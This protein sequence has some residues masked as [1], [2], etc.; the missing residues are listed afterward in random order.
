MKTWKTRR[1]VIL[2]QLD[3]GRSG[4]FLIKQDEMTLLVDTSIPQDGL[5]LASGLMEMGY[6]PARPVDYLVLTHSHFDHAGNA[7]MIQGEFL[8]TVVVH[9]LENE[10]L[11]KGSSPVPHG[12]SW[13]VDQL[14]TTF[15]RLA[16]GMTEFPA[17]AGDILVD[18]SLDLTEKGLPV[19]LIHTPGHTQ[20]SISVIVDGEIALTGDAMFGIRP[21]RTFPPFGNDPKEIIRSWK[22]LLDSGCSTF[23]PSH[24][25]E[26]SREVLQR[27]YERMAAGR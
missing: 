25:Q 9:T 10:F 19:K 8:A 7:A 14:I 15:G 22:V 1:G 17:L 16:G 11:Q 21:G 4:V 3:F 26:R 24:G 5:K 27:N 2:H 20:G 13:V 6:S 18:E 12:T 23:I